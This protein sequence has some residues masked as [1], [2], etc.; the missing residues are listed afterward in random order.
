MTARNGSNPTRDNPFLALV[1]GA[2]L[3]VLLWGNIGSAQTL[4]N[5]PP[6]TFSKPD[7]ADP[8]L[9]AFQDA[10]VSGVSLTRGNTRGLY[11]I[12]AESFFLR[13]TSP[14]DTEW[15][16]TF[17][18]PALPES[19]IRGSNF[20]ALHFDEWTTAHGEQPLA[21]LGR[22]AVLH[23]VSQDLYID[24]TMTAWTSGPGGG[25]A[26]VRSTPPLPPPVPTFGSLGQALGTIALS[27]GV[28]LSAQKGRTALHRRR[29]DRL[30]APGTGV[31]GTRQ[32][33]ADAT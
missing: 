27:I 22:P 15:A 33:A 30:S 26:Y 1:C 9:P 24:L 13:G 29:G 10:I 17:N 23:I 18:N 20:A 7:G 28:G 19:E 12:A 2:L 5:G 4:W 6:Q 32:E 14:A 31:P 25:F 16:W 21:T 3:L 11:N 8:T